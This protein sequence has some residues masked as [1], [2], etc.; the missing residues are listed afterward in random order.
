MTTVGL[1]SRIRKTSE[2]W[3]KSVRWSTDV[4]R[5][6]SEGSGDEVCHSPGRVITRNNGG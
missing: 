4:D 2:T 5:G 1:V 6:D 3:Y